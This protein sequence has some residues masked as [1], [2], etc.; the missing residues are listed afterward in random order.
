MRPKSAK[1]PRM[2]PTLGLQPAIDGRGDPLVGG[3]QRDP[4]MLRAARA[5]ELA[6]RDQ[7]AALREPADG[8]AARLAAGRP[9]IQPGLGVVDGRNPPTA[10]AGSSASRRRA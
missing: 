8:V 4:H 5:V 2:T 6:G 10:A 3:G 9:E 1:K 7:D